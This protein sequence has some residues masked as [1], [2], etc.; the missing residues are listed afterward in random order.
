VNGT[1]HQARS[2]T[3]TIK[4]IDLEK[5]SIRNTIERVM[6]TDTEFQVNEVPFTD[7]HWKLTRTIRR[8]QAQKY[9]LPGIL[10]FYSA[11]DVCMEFLCQ[12]KPT[13]VS[14]LVLSPAGHLKFW[15][16]S[17]RQE[18]IIASYHKQRVRFKEIQGLSED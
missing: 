13:E 4:K 7:Y 16:S 15:I 18:K 14:N 5:F 6:V 2:L 8:P 9:H 3:E 10:R 12:T 1:V 11:T 17:H